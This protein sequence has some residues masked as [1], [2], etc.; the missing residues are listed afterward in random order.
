MICEFCGGKTRKKRYRDSIGCAENYIS[1]RM[2]ILKYALP[3]GS[4]TSMQTLSIRLIVIYLPNI[5]SKTGLML[6]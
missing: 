4:A 2:S 3:A 1:S 6:K 5:R